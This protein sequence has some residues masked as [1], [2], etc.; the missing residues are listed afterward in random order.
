MSAAK[1]RLTVRSRSTHKMW[2]IKKDVLKNFAKITEKHMF[3]SLFFN[4]LPKTLLKKRP[5]HRC[6]PWNIG[7]FKDTYFVEHLRTVA[8]ED[9]N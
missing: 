7:N 3:R 4:K 2:S 5:R 1:V 9:Q 6:F 8:S